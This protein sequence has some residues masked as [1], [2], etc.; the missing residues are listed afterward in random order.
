MILFELYFSENLKR[1]FI[2]VASATQQASCTATTEASGF[3]CSKALDED[4]AT[5]YRVNSGV[6]SKDSSLN[7]IFARKY[8]INTVRITQLQG[9]TNQIEQI[10][11]SFDNVNDVE[12]VSMTT[13]SFYT[14]CF[15]LHSFY[16]INLTFVD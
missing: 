12:H 13:A 5:E 14:V 1:P 15:T 9:A 11:I 2:N 4:T 6:N 8:L 3:T 10:K 16:T 7:I